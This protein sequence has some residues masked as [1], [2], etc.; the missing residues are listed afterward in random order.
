MTEFKGLELVTMDRVVDSSNSEYK[1][2][3]NP[4]F[5]WF[6]EEEFKK[7][8]EEF[9]PTDYKGELNNKNKSSAADAAAVSKNTPVLGEKE[10]Q[11]QQS[12]QTN[13]NNNNNTDD[14]HR[15]ENGDSK[16]ESSNSILLLKIS[17]KNKNPP[18]EMTK[19]QYNSWNENEQK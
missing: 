7:L 16:E 15:G 3:L 5:N 10:Q 14:L 19:E 2:T 8:R 12:P 6:L 4:K 17:G 9:K 1:I 11:D 18:I 13:H